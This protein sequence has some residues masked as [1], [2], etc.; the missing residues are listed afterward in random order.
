MFV[1]ALTS[2]IPDDDGAL[3]LEFAPSVFAVEVAV[4]VAVSELDAS[5]SVQ[6]IPQLGSVEELVAACVT[7][8]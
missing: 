8:R 3:A 5:L 2:I 4:S 1:E 7:T 6:P